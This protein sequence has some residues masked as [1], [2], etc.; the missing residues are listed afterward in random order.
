[1]KIKISFDSITFDKFKMGVSNQ[2]TNNVYMYRV[3][4]D[5]LKYEKVLLK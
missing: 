2:G 5:G 4:K 1:M 3:I